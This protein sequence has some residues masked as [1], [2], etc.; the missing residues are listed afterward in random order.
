MNGEQLYEKIEA[1]LNGSLAAEELKSFE[2][3]LTKNP[4]L[5]AEVNLHRQLQNELSK[6]NKRTLRDNLKVIS[7]N[8]KVSLEDE[9]VSNVID[10]E[11]APANRNWLWWLLG[12]ALIGAAIFY[13][14][15]D[16]TSTI[17][18][19]LDEPMEE[20]ANKE[21]FPNIIK[22]KDPVDTDKELQQANNNETPSTDIKEEKPLIASVDPKDFIPNALLETQ[23]GST[24]RGNTYA[25][26]VDPTATADVIKLVGDVAQVRIKGSIE[27]DGDLD[28]KTSFMLMIY[29]N[30]KEDY[31]EDRSILNIPLNLQPLK[32][33]TFPFQFN[34]NMRIT[35]G[36]YYYIIAEKEDD[37]PLHVGRFKVTP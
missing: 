3:E 19:P 25:V 34:A 36:L 23:I 1:Y 35:P 12:L 17:E 31:M 26:N 7:A 11:A 5:S 29:S 16:T 15:K 20:P 2:Q 30:K 21:E 9:D 24:V 32:D 14:T 22:P 4:A 18:P 6:S 37:E 33:N 13:F 28:E 10:K 27:V 8:Q